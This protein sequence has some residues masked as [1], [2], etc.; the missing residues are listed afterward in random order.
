MARYVRFVAGVKRGEACMRAA[1]FG[2]PRHSITGMWECTFHEIV[3]EKFVWWII[4]FELW[5]N[6]CFPFQNVSLHCFVFL[7]I[8]GNI[9]LF[10]PTA[11]LGLY[12]SLYSSNGVD[13][14]NQTNYQMCTHTDGG[15]N[16]WW[17][18]DLGR[19]EDVAEVRILNRDSYEDRL[20]GA[21]IRVGQWNTSFLFMMLP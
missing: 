18:V 11:Q 1:I 4:Y 17:R 8:Q 15:P 16:P 7:L 19:V 3:K 13:G 20:D 10:K 2:T 5:K 9:A 21:E 6:L 12:G 14:G